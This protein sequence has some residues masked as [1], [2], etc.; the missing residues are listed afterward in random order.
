MR[1]N[2]GNLLIAL[3]ISALIAYGLWAAGD[4]LK[5][6]V[7]IGCFAYLAGTLCPA[8]GIQY[9]FQRSALNLRVVCG[10]FFVLGLAVNI[11]FALMGSSPTAYILTS[12]IS[13]LVY[14]FL[15]NI[16]YGTRQ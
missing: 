13:F 3:T 16:I 15:G 10:V 7:G 11:G 4:D 9:E 14:L 6:Y 12:A 2:L 5:N 1:P 8:I